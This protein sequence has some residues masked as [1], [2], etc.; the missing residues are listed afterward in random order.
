MDI[1]VATADFNEERLQRQL[2]RSIERALRKGS[3]KYK[4]G[5]H[6]INLNVINGETRGVGGHVHRSPLR[7]RSTHECDLAKHLSVKDISKS[8]DSGVCTDT[9]DTEEEESDY[10]YDE[11]ASVE[12]DTDFSSSSLFI[13]PGG[14]ENDIQR[15]ITPKKSIPKQASLI[16]SNASL[17]RDVANK[18]KS[19]TRRHKEKD[20]TANYSK[21]D[22][23]DLMTRSV[24]GSLASDW[25]DSGDNDGAVRRTGSKDTL[26]S[27]DNSRSGSISSKYK[28]TGDSPLRKAESRDGILAYDPS[29]YRA[30]SREG[31]LP[32][33]PSIRRALS[34]EGIRTCD[35]E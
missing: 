27:G 7:K 18:S 8:I 28:N 9:R 11:V 1:Y 16:D 17:P 10:E 12:D 6:L 22:S 19:L 20:T 15:S 4:E 23:A 2:Q 3:V 31:I 24:V 34:R 30:R 29:I 21:F 32:H 33:D 35:S 14:L 25:I 26:L 13:H 5:Q